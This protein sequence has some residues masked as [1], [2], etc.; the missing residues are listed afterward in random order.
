MTPQQADGTLVV[1]RLP[2]DQAEEPP[3]VI[4]GPPIPTL[5][6]MS[7]TE[8]KEA[9]RALLDATVD[10]TIRRQQHGLMSEQVKFEFQSSTL[11]RRFLFGQA[12]CRQS[13]LQASTAQ[14]VQNTTANPNGKN[15]RSLHSIPHLCPRPREQECL[16]VLAPFRYPCSFTATGLMAP[17][18]VG[19]SGSPRRCG[20]IP[21]AGKRNGPAR[22]AS[23][24]AVDK[25]LLPRSIVPCGS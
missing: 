16:T 11:F 25:P 22:A 10:E 24:G 15:C 20:L 13:L 23:L 3:V 14:I 19:F 5:P 9:Q 17:F 7:D 21:V 6:Q 4:T 2:F 1:E 8:V 12:R 18:V